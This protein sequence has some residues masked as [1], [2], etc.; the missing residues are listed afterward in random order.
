MPT[1]LSIETETTN[2][3]LEDLDILF[4]SD[5]PLVWRAEHDFAQRAKKGGGSEAF[6]Q[7]D[8]NIEQ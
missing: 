4:A 1:G 3:H 2:R 8:N 7:I 6:V 5:S